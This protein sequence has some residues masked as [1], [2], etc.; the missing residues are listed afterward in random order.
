MKILLKNSLIAT[1]EGLIKGDI[2]IENEK[3]S[4]ISSKIEEKAD[5][6]EECCG[7]FIIPGGIDVHTHFNIDV[8]IKSIDDFYSGG[9]AAA[10]G[11]TTTII[12]HPGFGPNRCS[13]DYQIERY[14]EAA[15]NCPIDY[16]FHGVLQWVPDN[17]EEQ[18]LKLKKDGITSF[19]LYTTY[20]YA[21]SDDEII[22][23]FKIAKKLDLVIAVH[24]EN[25]EIINFE[26]EKYRVENTTTPEYHAKSRP[27]IA[28]YDSVCRL[29]NL[30]KIVG[31]D[32]LYF[33]HISTKEVINY[34]EKEKLAGTKF[35]LESC[36]QYL[37]LTEEAYKKENGNLFILSPPLRK[38]EDNKEILMGIKKDL[39]DIIATDHCSFSI[40]DKE[41]GKTNFLKAPNGIPGVQERIPL[42]F[43]SFLKGEISLKSFLNT[44]CVNPAKIFGIY[45]QKGSISIGS[46]A[47]LVIIENIKNRISIKS[48]AN[49]SCYEEIENRV[50]IESVYLRGKKILQQNDLLESSKGKFIDK[51]R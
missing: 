4:K 46:D 28:E 31:F 34:L 1:E 39:I 15:K 13:L 17:L 6:I 7:K 45:P 3:I 24:A 20:T 33:V 32:K 27:N 44:C 43:S 26:R 5:I 41:I 30:A 49:Y 9:I 22:K 2:L 11:G 36:P 50:S 42:M 18:M 19:K 8:G 14:K 51:R 21:L 35:Y 10:F 40:K 37:Y 48:R 25:N 16:S 47:D 38:E 29:L 23:V 12:D